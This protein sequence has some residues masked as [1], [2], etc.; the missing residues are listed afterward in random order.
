MADPLKRPYNFRILSVL[1]LVEPHAG[2]SELFFLFV[3]ES[4]GS[5]P[6][7]LSLRHVHFSKCL[8]YINII[9][10][11]IVFACLYSSQ[12]YK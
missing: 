1:I 3:S 8:F 2:S 12:K 6:L 4:L 9:L 11:G 5:V 10:P 7:E